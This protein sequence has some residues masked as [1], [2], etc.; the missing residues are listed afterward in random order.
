MS[1]FF[2]RKQR[3]RSPTPEWLYRKP[4]DNT[5][6][7]SQIQ[8]ELYASRIRF[9]NFSATAIGR[10]SSGGILTLSVNAVDLI[11]LNV[12]R[13]ECTPVPECEDLQADEDAW[14]A[15]LCQLAPRWW[16]SLQDRDRAC[17]E[18]D[19]ERF[20]T[21]VEKEKIYVGWPSNGDGVWVLRC[22]GEH[23]PNKFSVYDMCLNMDERCEV[24]Q[25]YGAQ[26]YSDPKECLELTEQYGEK[27]RRE[28]DQLDN[29][30]NEK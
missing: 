21:C 2:S 28:R 23:P 27:F 10:P 7:S 24:L 6:S 26:F 20:K 30:W 17:D 3:T 9:G 14:C 5:P 1:W 18:S 29:Y 12:S 25:K 13:L 4:S 19:I 11:F 8:D 16:R 22:P 15:R